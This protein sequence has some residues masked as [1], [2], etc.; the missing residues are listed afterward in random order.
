MPI[1]TAWWCLG[2]PLQILTPL[3]EGVTPLWTLLR[4]SRGEWR[5]IIQGYVNVR[6][7]IQSHYG[8][9]IQL[10][11]AA[12]TVPP[13]R[14][15]HSGHYTSNN[16]SPECF[17]IDYFLISTYRKW[18]KMATKNIHQSC[19]MQGFYS[20]LSRCVQT[21]WSCHGR[22]WCR[23]EAAERREVPWFYVN[24]YSLRTSVQCSRVGGKLL[25]LCVCVSCI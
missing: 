16:F 13:A 9:R 22:C 12:S 20:L 5:I 18:P 25:D 7:I 19:K 17:I 14:C 1:M 6:K 11:C 23:A 10:H 8:N 21:C 4:R 15:I 2:V 3:L 24:K